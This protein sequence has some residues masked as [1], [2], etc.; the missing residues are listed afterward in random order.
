M[1]KNNHAHEFHYGTPGT[2]Y[3]FTGL[4]GAGKTT[5]GTL[6]FEAMRRTDNNTIYL[7]GDIIRQ[8]LGENHNHEVSDRKKLAMR[9]SRLCQMLSNQGFGVVIATIS[10]FHDVHRWN[11][12]NIKDY[13]EIYLK[14]PLDVLRERDQKGLY[15]SFEAGNV[16][17]I[18][19]FDQEIQEPET[20]DHIIYNNGSVGAEELAQQL[21]DK[22]CLV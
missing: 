14:V 15:S 7:D 18:A 2:V 21:V 11:R 3:W 20:P 9:Y 1:N 22:I 4:S 5:I 12:E 10:L 13:C 17:N 16:K 8:V 19:G 6:F